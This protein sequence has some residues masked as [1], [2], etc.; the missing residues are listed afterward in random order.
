MV[1][2]EK[3]VVWL[4]FYS[5]RMYEVYE[6]LM[7]QVNWGGGG[8]CSWEFLVV[9]LCRSLLQILTLFQTRKCHFPHPLSD[10]THKIHTRF[11]TWPFGRNYV[12]TLLVIIT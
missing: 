6:V 9:G 1:Q 2:C 8:G 3:T 4:I 10:Q 12:I 5:V 11:Q 7:S